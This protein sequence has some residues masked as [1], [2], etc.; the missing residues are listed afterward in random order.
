MKEHFYKNLGKYGFVIAAAFIILAILFFNHNWSAL[1]VNPKTA[2]LP[3]ITRDYE[4]FK[5]YTTLLFYL[6]SAIGSILSSLLLIFLYGGWKQQHNKSVMADE[7]KK[8]RNILVDLSI[9]TLDLD[10]EYYY[11]KDTDPLCFN[12]NEKIKLKIENI[13][14]NTDNALIRFKHFDELAESKKARNL[15]ME[16]YGTFKDYKSYLEK[17]GDDEKI[18]DV[19]IIESN[20][21]DRLYEEN[22]NVR[23]YLKQFILA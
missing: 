4:E 15:F 3:E 1:G 17:I 10:Y 18:E 19:Q 23:K 8:L 6:I 11:H 2:M 5:D 13:I 21:R 12:D 7:A 16:F 20:F 14:K 22:E 9:E